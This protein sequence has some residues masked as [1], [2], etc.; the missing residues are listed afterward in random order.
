MLWSS[1]TDRSV[2]HSRVSITSA[3]L[4]LIAVFASVVRFAIAELDIS[5][6]SDQFSGLYF[7]PCDSSS[8]IISFLTSCASNLVLSLYAS[9]YIHQISPL[10]LSMSSI[11]FITLSC[12]ASLLSVHSSICLIRS[13]LSFII[14]TVCASSQFHDETS[15]S[16]MLTHSVLFGFITA[17]TALFAPCMPV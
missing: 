1:S 10:S 17:S 13:A 15:L 14:L 6:L 12:K 5:K 11:M 2:F 8:T 16:V 3:N 4:D 9:L 7:T